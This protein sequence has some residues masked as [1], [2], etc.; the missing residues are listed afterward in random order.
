MFVVRGSG[1]AAQQNENTDTNDALKF[2]EWSP[3]VV[4]RF[5]V[6]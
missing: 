3:D 1:G 4:E 6:E 2:C 5:E